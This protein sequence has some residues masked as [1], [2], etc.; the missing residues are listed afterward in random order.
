[1]EFGNPQIFVYWTATLTSSF[2]DVT[3]PTYCVP[4]HYTVA[5]LMG[6]ESYN[7]SFHSSN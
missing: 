3:K 1:M 4:V 6:I 2:T 5:Q 7:I